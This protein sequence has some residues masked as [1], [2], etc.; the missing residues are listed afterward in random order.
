MHFD[1]TETMK[2][3]S[4]AELLKI[5]TT[6]RDDY[7]EGAVK[8]AETELSK[9]NLSIEEIT[10]AEM[11]NEQQQQI[12]LKKANAPL[13]SHWKILTFIFPG[14]IN[15]IF[16]G[17]FKGDGYDRKANELVKWTLYG[18]GFYIGFILLISLL[19]L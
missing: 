4:N 1:F 2:Q 5:V 16:S 11:F 13:E 14:V 7:Q 17:T 9:R 10:A 18:V 6:D 12:L 3:A 19:S 15:F 8:A